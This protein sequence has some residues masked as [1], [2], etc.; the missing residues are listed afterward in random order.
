M[1]DE[2]APVLVPW[3]SATTPT[4]QAA[5]NNRSVFSEQ[6]FG[7]TKTGLKLGC[8]QNCVSHAW[9]RWPGEICSHSAQLWL[10]S[11]FFG[12]WL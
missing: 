2:K 8:Q 1:W 10:A 9:G 3:G 7:I 5:Q 11:T 4:T 12:L 6:G